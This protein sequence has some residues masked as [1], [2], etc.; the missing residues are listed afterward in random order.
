M[1]ASERR[2]TQIV[3]TDITATIT[4]LFLTAI[5]PCFLIS[6]ITKEEWV[7]IVCEHSVVLRGLRIQFSQL[8][9]VSVKQTGKV[10]TQTCSDYILT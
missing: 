10:Q 1:L 5:E 4:M 3:M 8:I 6:F 9:K 7:Q 2:H